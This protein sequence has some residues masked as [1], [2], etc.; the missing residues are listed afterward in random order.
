MNSPQ[1]ILFS[2]DIP[3]SLSALLAD[4]E[5]G[6][7]FVITDANVERIVLPRLALDY[8]VIA[9]PAGDDHKNLASLSA[10]WERLVELGAT[11]ASVIINIGGGV[12]TD[13]GGFAA[14]TFK[15]GVRFIN[16]PTTLLSAVDAAVGGKTGINFAG[17]KN[18][19]GAFAPA[20]GVVIS[21][22]T[23]S[24]L[25]PAELLSGYAEMIKHALLSSPEEY[26][27]IL[28]YTPLEGDADRLLG[29]L[30]ESVR[31]KERIV[32]Q[33]PTER[34]LRRALNLG[35]TVGHAFESF[36]LSKGEPLP[37][38]HAVAAGLVAELVISHLQK[39]FPTS[40][41]YPLRD[42]IRQNGYILP[43]FTCDDYPR[44]LALMSHDKKNERAGRI[45]FTLLSA[46]GE[47]HIDCN[48]EPAE[49]SPA[50]DIYRDLLE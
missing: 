29:L 37:H 32:D 16:V 10:V 13:L 30:T 27:E 33:D 44:L 41:I 2:N 25:P 45:N 5:P 42:F 40:L 28:A 6:G 39:G 3:A 22:S 48:L 38:G 34:G 31:V 18:E 47:I 43:S 23:F 11:R 49:V 26:A 17:L 46:P 1:K 19:V 14:A 21:A 12:A 9:I 36:A 7:V 15:R 20:A 24:T 8:P 35:H 4:M 50:L